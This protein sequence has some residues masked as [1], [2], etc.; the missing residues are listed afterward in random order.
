MCACAHRAGAEAL[1][2]KVTR[3]PAVMS[4]RTG[5]IA[6]AAAAMA[7]IGTTTSAGAREVVRSRSPA[8]H[9]RGQDG[10]AAALP[11]P[12]RGDRDPLYGRSRPTRQAVAG[13][14]PR[15]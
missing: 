13:Q 6:L 7:L 10:R 11:R 1:T 5:W 2:A 9:H 14:G 4:N 12:R 15:E 8:R 3:G